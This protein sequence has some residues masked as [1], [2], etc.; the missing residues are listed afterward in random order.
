MTVIAS[1][2]S[3]SSSSQAAWLVG[4]FEKR[5]LGQSVLSTNVIEA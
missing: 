4:P 3:I 1:I 5:K 2:T